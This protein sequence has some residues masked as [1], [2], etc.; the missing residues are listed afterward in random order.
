MAL[1][2]GAAATDYVTMDNESNFDVEYTTGMTWEFWMSVTAAS[3]AGGILN[4]WQP[5]PSR[6]WL[7]WTIDY[8]GTG[9]AMGMIMYGAVGGF[10]VY[11]DGDIESEPTWSHYAITYNG[12]GLDHNVKFYYNGVLKTTLASAAGHVTGSILHNTAFLIGKGAAAAQVG[13]YDEIR[14]WN[15][16]RTQAQIQAYMHRR[17]MSQANLLAL[18]RCDNG[19]DNLAPGGKDLTD[20]SGGAN[21]GTFSGSPSWTTGAPIIW[22]PA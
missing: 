12:D 4:K 21:H 11:A 5:S 8:G 9:K 14:Y 1:V 7:V 16:T 10:Q 3:A 22:K 17:I 18:W 2:L 13:S 15:V 6:G 19:A 20:L